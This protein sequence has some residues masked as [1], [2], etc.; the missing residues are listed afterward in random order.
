M[1]PFVLSAAWLTTAVFVLIAAIAAT[2]LNVLTGYAGQIS[3]GHAFFLAAGAYG[4]VA[5]ADAGLPSP[6]WILAAGIIAAAF[7]AL[8]GPIALRLSG[9]YL[10]LVTLGLSS[11]AS[12]CCSTS[13]GSRGDRRGARSRPWRSARSTS[14]TTRSPSARC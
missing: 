2:G 1:L 4:A 10:A 12:T 8:A 6:L 14:R 9:L 13:T 3:L 11:S 5:L 7:G